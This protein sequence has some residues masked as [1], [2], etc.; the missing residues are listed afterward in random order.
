MPELD[1]LYNAYYQKRDAVLSGD[2][3]TKQLVFAAV[4][5]FEAWRAMSRAE[6]IIRERVNAP[7]RRVE[8][9]SMTATR[10]YVAAYELWQAI[11]ALGADMLSEPANGHAEAAPLMS[12]SEAAEYARGFPSWE[13]EPARDNRP[14]W[15]KRPPDATYDP[16][17]GEWAIGRQ[18]VGQGGTAPEPEPTPR[19]Q[20]QCPDCD[21]TGIETIQWGGHTGDVR[22]RQ[23]VTCGGSGHVDG[24]DAEAEWLTPENAQAW[25]DAEAEAR[26]TGEPFPLRECSCKDPNPHNDGERGD[27]T[28]LDCGGVIPNPNDARRDAGWF[29]NDGGPDYPGRDALRRRPRFGR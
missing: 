29:G 9:A 4:K 18:L 27:V 26:A 10:V 8:S 20:V 15:E 22:T 11:E 17:T 28:C 16:A 14:E 1:A 7:M 6:A 12:A 2:E 19:Q 25:R 23:C 13:S 21:G 3:A 24:P 5:S